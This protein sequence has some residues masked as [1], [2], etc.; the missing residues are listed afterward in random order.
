MLEK[1]MYIIYFYI[2]HPDGNLHWHGSTVSSVWTNLSLSIGLLAIFFFFPFF[3]PEC[4][5][6]VVV[7][8]Q[9]CF[10]QFL[11]KFNFYIR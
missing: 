3:P 1:R 7:F 9:L 10:A 2:A 6:H 8:L 4:H 5:D 11:Y